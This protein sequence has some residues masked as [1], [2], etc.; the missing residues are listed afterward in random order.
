MRPSIKTSVSKTDTP[1]KNTPTENRK[2]REKA[3]EFLE[4]AT[5]NSLIIDHEIAFLQRDYTKKSEQ[6]FIDLSN[7]LENSS[8]I[9]QQNQAFFDKFEAIA[10]KNESLDGFRMNWS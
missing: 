1:E 6:S 7:K 4:K 10:N 9:L 2:K 8:K 5:N 3:K